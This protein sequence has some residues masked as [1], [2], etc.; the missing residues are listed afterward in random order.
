MIH[1]TKHGSQ[2]RS[3]GKDHL[4]EF[5]TSRKFVRLNV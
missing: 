2:L 4:P 1:P 3:K 5:A